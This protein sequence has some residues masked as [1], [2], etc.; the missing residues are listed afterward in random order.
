MLARPS[1]QIENC[2]IPTLIP[3]V[4]KYLNEVLRT[5]VMAVPSVGLSFESKIFNEDS[6]SFYI[7]NQQLTLVHFGFFLL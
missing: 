4:I 3:E 1:Q 7:V 6:A 5:T 2:N